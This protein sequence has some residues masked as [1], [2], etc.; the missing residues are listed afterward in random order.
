MGHWEEN[1]PCTE[2][3]LLAAVC[4]STANECRRAGMLY[5]LV[6]L[7][8]PWLILIPVSQPKPMWEWGFIENIQFWKRLNLQL[9]TQCLQR[10]A[11]I[12]WLVYVWWTGTKVTRRAF[13]TLTQ[14]VPSMLLDTASQVLRSLLPKPHFWKICLEYLVRRLKSIHDYKYV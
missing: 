6:F 2:T 11:W 9:C 4:H 5:P 14:V 3:F 7:T 10:T 12:W 1:I 8:C 13:L